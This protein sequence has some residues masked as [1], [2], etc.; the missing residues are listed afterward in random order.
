MALVHLAV[1]VHPTLVPI[2]LADG[3]LEE[4]LTALTAHGTIV[5]TFEEKRE[6]FI[7]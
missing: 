7:K 6:L 1:I 2:L 3:T 5:T 4:S